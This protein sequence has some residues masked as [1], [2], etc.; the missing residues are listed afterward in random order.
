VEATAGP[1]LPAELAAEVLQRRRAFEDLFLTALPNHLAAHPAALTGMTPKVYVNTCLG[2]VNWCYK[3]Y[4]S[5]PEELGEQIA[6]AHH[7]DRPRP[8]LT[9]THHHPALSTGGFSPPRT[10]P[11]VVDRR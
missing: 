8:A 10:L 7:G 3:W 9:H 5:R 11:L 1:R 2:A 6:R 4:P